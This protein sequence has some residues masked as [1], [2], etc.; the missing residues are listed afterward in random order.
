LFP[1]SHPI[2]DELAD[3][4]ADR[5]ADLTCSPIVDAAVEPADDRFLR[6][7]F[8]GIELPGRHAKFDFGAVGKTEIIAEQ[9]GQDYRC[10]AGYHTVTAG[11][12]RKRRRLQKWSPVF[13]DVLVDV[14]LRSDEI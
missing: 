11:I 2:Q 8:K 3:I 9:I 13:I 12:F 5:R 1:G 7:L 6:R 10:G 14:G 4:G